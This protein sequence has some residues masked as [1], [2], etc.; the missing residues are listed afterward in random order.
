MLTFFELVPSYVFT[1]ICDVE[2]SIL[3]VGLCQ[4]VKR[5]HQLLHA[6]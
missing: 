3:P 2:L 5:G 6:R 4:D 1:E